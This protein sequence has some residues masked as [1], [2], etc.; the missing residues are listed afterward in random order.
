MVP[1]SSKARSVIQSINQPTESIEPS[2]PF[3]SP[4]LARGGRRA[5]LGQPA[6]EEGKVRRHRQQGGGRPAQEGQEDLGPCLIKSLVFMLLSV[7]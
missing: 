5:L 3:R 7:V 4:Y 6:L 2:L 1:D